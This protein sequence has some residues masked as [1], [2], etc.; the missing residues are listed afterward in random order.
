M[1][2]VERRAVEE[3]YRQN[4]RGRVGEMLLKNGLVEE[5]QLF[6]ALQRQIHLLF[7]RLAEE[8]ME[9]FTFWSGPLLYAQERLRLNATALML[10]A[11]RVKDEKGKD[12]YNQT[13]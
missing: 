1:G 3:A 7:Q 12:E 2:L 10:E 9:R 6:L 13:A 5:R 8:P 11:M 4:P